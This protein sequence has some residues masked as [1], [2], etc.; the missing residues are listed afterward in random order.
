MGRVAP[1]ETPS[2]PNYTLCPQLVLAPPAGVAC[3]GGVRV[4]FGCARLEYGHSDLA[5]S[6]AGRAPRAR[7][8]NNDNGG[9]PITKSPG[10][11]PQS[12]QQA[13]DSTH[14]LY[15][16]QAEAPGRGNLVR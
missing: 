7:K 1:T 8:W 4:L 13:Q 3:N 2:A 9:R 5:I 15:G 11:L 14:D 12:R 10:H 16:E 6:L